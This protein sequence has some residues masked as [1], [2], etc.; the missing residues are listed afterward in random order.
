MKKDSIKLKLLSIISILIFIIAATTIVSVVH[1]FNIYTN[2]LYGQYV[3]GGMD[4]IVN[5]IEDSKN[6]VKGYATLFASR[7]DII[8]M[9]ESKDADKLFQ[10]MEPIVKQANLDFVTITDNTGNVILRT[11]DRD[12]KG[13]SVS[14]Q[15][16]VQK[17]LKGE[18]VSVI[19]EGTAVKLSVRA[20]APVKNSQGQVVG[21]ISTGY[22]L[23]KE[24]FVDDIKNKFKVEVTLF[25][26]DERISTTITENGKRIIGTK[27]SSNIADK[28]LKQ[29]KDYEGVAE[30]LNS[31]Y[32]GLYKPLIGP[33][34][35]TIGIIFTGK[36]MADF[37]ALRIKIIINILIATNVAIIIT[38]IILYM[39]LNKRIVNPI[40]KISSV[41]ERAAQG[42]LTLTS[43]N[44]IKGIGEIRTLEKSAQDMND[45]TLNT[46]K[47]IHG[48]SKDIDSHSQNLNV[49]S[50]EMVSA[51]TEI[52][53]AVNEV[54]VGTSN[55]VGQLNNIVTAV[56][57][58]SL[59]L[60]KIVKDINEVELNS[61]NINDMANESNISME[62]LIGSVLSVKASFEKF[63]EKFRK[64]G[65][66][67]NKINEI[68]NVINN[69]AEETNMLALNAAIEA[70][71]AGE[72][73]RGFAVVANEIRKLSYESKVSSENINILINNIWD[74]TNDMIQNNSDMNSEINNQ[75]NKIN[76]SVSSFEDIIKAINEVIPK[77]HNINNSTENINIEKKS[78]LRDTQE[79][80]SIAEEVSAAAEQ[81][82]ASTEEMNS[83]SE[84][85]SSMSEVLT[86]MTKKMIE[87]IK[88]FKI[89]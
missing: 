26:K 77:I 46:I 15:Y 27:V 82:S 14:N 34:N 8:Q 13:D 36:S 21:V 12:K 43:D 7:P 44:K 58:F 38:I 2:E 45:N 6:N 59:E 29:N 31:S 85:L 19:E 66:N 86:N 75:I 79:A 64:L 48:T 10:V 65:D 39:W 74:E 11:H 17:A 1:F 25:L 37:N 41:L 83:L 61:K 50:E 76:T 28:V 60:D 55:Q 71:R 68:T 87:K 18:C 54:A 47:M 23:T 69:I 81:I 30:I 80:A 35:N 51:S 24:K 16:N 88:Y 78:I 22:D 52:A 89:Q 9:I 4:T 72:S 49:I 33:E 70:A 3:T 57:K 84:E 32:K 53:K 63:T 40:K 56:N 42:D 5:N 20:G 62:T 67:I 73:G